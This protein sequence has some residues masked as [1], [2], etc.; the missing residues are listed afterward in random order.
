MARR[1]HSIVLLGATGFTG[2]FVLQELL[3]SSAGLAAPLAVAGRNGEKLRQLLLELG[4]TNQKDIKVRNPWIRG[5][6]SLG[7]ASKLPAR[8]SSLSTAGCHLSGVQHIMT[9]AMGCRR[10]G[11]GGRRCVRPGQPEAHGCLNAACHQRCGSLP[12]GKR[13][14]QSSPMLHSLRGGT[15]KSLVTITI[16]VCM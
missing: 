3:A 11:A 2:R 15:A 9:A 16:F 6:P 8:G 4:A 13:S 7:C 14:V 5:Y 12:P 10:A 1:E